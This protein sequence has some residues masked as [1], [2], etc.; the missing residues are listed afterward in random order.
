M[1]KVKDNILPFERIKINDKVEEFF[2]LFITILSC[3]PSSL[4]CH[5]F[6]PRKI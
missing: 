2:V 5:V 4:S 3:Y 1:F 6:R